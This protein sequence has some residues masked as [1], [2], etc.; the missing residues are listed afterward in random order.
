MISKKLSPT[1]KKSIFALMTAIVCTTLIIIIYFWEKPGKIFGIIL[2]TLIAMFAIFEFVKSF[3]LPIWAKLFIPLSSVFIM[4]TPLNNDF[5]NF[6]NVDNETLT[7]LPDFG[8]P[9]PE[10]ALILI[11][12]IQS[13]FKFSIAAIPF[14]A[15]PILIIL[16]LIPCLFSED[17]SKIFS[18]FLT[19]FIVVILT[20]FAVKF[21]LYFTILQFSLILILMSSVIL[22]DS[23]AYFVGKLLGNKF[24]IRKLAPTI[25]PNKTI[26][27]AIA[28]YVGGF[29][30]LF[31]FFW[32]NFSRIKY[33]FDSGINFGK[34][35]EFDPLILLIVIPI[36]VPLIAILGDLLF[37]F[38][39][40]RLEIKD[41]SNLIPSH[42]GLLDRFDSLILVIFV[43][44]TLIAILGLLI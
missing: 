21:L 20:S 38:I 7:Q 34:L 23:L 43:F 13:Q 2:F 8:S 42:G 27:G 14:I 9:Y 18:N 32:L 31:I 26:E 33:G 11:Q 22:T 37:S 16:I 36:I 12:L 25:S 15:F 30:F 19:I 39:K 28:G 41:F 5:I 29:L 35:S 17:K 44:G 4:L 10:Y 1:F 3:R 40:R 6:I 24:F